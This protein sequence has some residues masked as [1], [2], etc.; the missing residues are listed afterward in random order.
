MANLKGRRELQV[1]GVLTILV[2][3]VVCT[4]CVFY[5]TTSDN[6]KY[7]SNCTMATRMLELDSKYVGLVGHRSS[8]GRHTGDKDDLKFFLVAEGFV[9]AATLI[10][11]GSIAVI[12][13][14][15]HWLEYQTNC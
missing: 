1:K 2:L 10:V 14:T 13:N 3:A 6:Q 11:S 9:S 15:I 4:S 8:D 12:G 7:S 5:P